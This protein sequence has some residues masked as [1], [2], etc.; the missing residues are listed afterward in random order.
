MFRLPVRLIRETETEYAL[1]EVPRDR[2]LARRE[3][4]TELHARLLAELAPGAEIESERY[5][6]AVAD[7]KIVVTL[8]A[9]CSENIAIEVPAQQQE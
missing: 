5:S 3:L 1:A 8:R 9:R 7:G 6:A 2:N 4:E